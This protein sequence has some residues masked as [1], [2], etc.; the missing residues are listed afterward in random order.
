MTI[1]AVRTHRLSAPLH[2]PFVTALR[3]TTTVDTLVAEVVDADGRRGV[4]EAPQVWQVTGASTAGS[5]A[6]VREV[7]GPLLTG[8]DPDDLVARC[9]EVGRAVAGNEAAKSAVDVALHDLAAR[10]LGVPLVR[11]LGG[12]AL[13]VPTD[14]TLAAGDAVDLAAAA[15]ARRSEG[16]DVLKLKVGTDAAGDLD[17]VRAVRSAVGA[18]VRIRLDANQGWTPRDAVRVIRGIEDAGLDVELVEQPVPRWDL[19]GLAWVS[20]RV[21]TPI[22]ADEAVFGVRDLVE[23][24]RRR[25]ADLVNVKLAKC[26]GLHVARTLLDLAV[27]H[28]M[29][30]VVGSMMETQVG[31][32]AAASLVAA[33]GTTAV[34][35]LDAAWWLAWSPVRGGPR[36]EG[37]SVVL[38]DAPGLGID[39]LAEAKIQQV[40]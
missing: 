29:G 17:R 39:A 16:F 30:T 21:S 27:A 33:Y 24:I 31:I 14:V 5:E 26:G 2:T 13:R 23:V 25:A 22:L 28:G 9:T 32:G 3:R 18:R 7:L 8:R 40:D 38:A 36:Y 12:T 19:D 4:G 15:R 35:D 37:A 6:C 20:E 1:T 10:R 11:L 34:P